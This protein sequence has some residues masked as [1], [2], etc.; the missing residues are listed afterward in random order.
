MLSTGSGNS[1]KRQPL[2]GQ[3][4]T[5]VYPPESLTQVAP[6]HS[7]EPL[8]TGVPNP[9]AAPVEVAPQIAETDYADALK[10]A[11][12]RGAEAAAKMQQ[13]PNS[14]ASCPNL[15]AFDPDQ[16]ND[17]TIV[18]SLV[19]DPLAAEPTS[20]VIP[21]PTPNTSMDT[22][23]SISLPDIHTI[24][25]RAQVEE[26]KRKKRLARNRASARMRRLRKKHLVDAYEGEVGV[27]EA[28]LQKLR[29]HVWGTDTC[30]DLLEALSMERGQQELFDNER[31]EII[32]AIMVQEL[33]QLE[34]LQE[35]H[36][37]QMVLLQAIDNPNEDITRELN[38]LLNLTEVQKGNIREACRDIA[39]EA[40]AIKVFVSCLQVMQGRW[41]WNNSA[42]E[43]SKQCFKILQPNQLSKFLLW[44]DANAEVIDELELCVPPPANTEPQTGP[45]F[46]FGTSGAAPS[47]SFQLPVD[48]T[49]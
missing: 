4:A 16:P 2:P 12:R 45:I 48:D 11:Y 23:R 37:E 31:M 21:I 28:S 7:Q 46:V 25:M 18:P 43:M 6:S 38:D 42:E 8:S 22:S 5:P 39:N 13:Q 15:K 49:E 44:A 14:V 10:E 27:L 20:V 17:S 30:E 26:A 29:S 19:P 9:L 24:D 41:L 40:R 33:R 34:L 32:D 3:W 35:A 1:A 47:V 36:L